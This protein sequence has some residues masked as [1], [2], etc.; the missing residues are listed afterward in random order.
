MAEKKV[1]LLSQSANGYVKQ[2]QCCQKIGIGFKNL[3]IPLQISD[4]IAFKDYINTLDQTHLEKDT[5]ANAGVN[6]AFTDVVI[7]L[8]R[9]EFVQLHTLIAAAEI[10]LFRCQ[11]ERHYQAQL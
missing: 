4:F 7:R 10:E 9:A 5:K 2:C 6:L 8:D 3:Y 11:L 1:M